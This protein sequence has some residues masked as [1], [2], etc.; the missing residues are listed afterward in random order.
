MRFCVSWF[1]N[2]VSVTHCIKP[3][4]F[5]VFL[6]QDNSWTLMNQSLYGHP[7]LGL[8]GA[9]MIEAPQHLVLL[10]GT[11]GMKNYDN[12]FSYNEHFGFFDTGVKL[13][14]PKYEMAA[15]ALKKICHKKENPR[16]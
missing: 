10:G 16:F 4:S 7:E 2:R 12:V 3:F 8:Y 15:V 6:L 14:A 9:S 5:Q 1:V 11:D 13:S